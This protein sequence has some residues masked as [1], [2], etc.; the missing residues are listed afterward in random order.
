MWREPFARLGVFDHRDGH[1]P[2]PFSATEDV[3]VAE[4]GIRADVV[5]DRV[6]I[7]L[8]RFRVLC[9]LFY[10]FFRNG[11]LFFGEHP[12]GRALEGSQVRR[13][14]RDF[15][16]ALH[17]ARC[18]ANHCD[19]LVAHIEIVGPGAGVDEIASEGFP[20][21]DVGPF[22]FAEHSLRTYHHVGDEGLSGCRRDKPLGCIVM[23]GCAGD[24]GVQV[25]HRPEVE[26]VDGCTHVVEDLWL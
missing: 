10:L 6:A 9:E 21:A 14:F 2:G 26:F 19:A 1:S 25:D 5:H 24:T 18:T 22:H 8:K 3:F 17:G 7:A 11:E 15:R 4:W 16:D 20:T 23:P 13:E 12:L